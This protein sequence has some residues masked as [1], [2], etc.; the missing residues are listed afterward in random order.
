M[1]HQPQ[2]FQAPD[3]TE[4]VVLTASDYER[5]A[6]LAEDAEDI[7]AGRAGLASIVQDGAVPG[8]VVA[9]MIRDGLS[10][11]AAWRRHRGLTQTELARRAGLS[12][13]WVNRI[14]AGKGH[15]T[16]ATRSRL[17]AALD[18]PGWALEDAAD[19]DAPAKEQTVKNK[20]MFKIEIE[21]QL[22]HAR[23]TG[24]TSLTLSAGDVHRAVGGYPGPGHA[25]P[26]CC[27]ALRDMADALHAELVHSPPKGNGASLAFRFAIC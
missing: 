18:A 15:G 8:E 26:T 16:P 1:N 20:Q 21:R 10:P 23:Q 24:K 2:R 17:A 25:M 6:L 27:A 19:P 22:D 3:G 5:L 4:M 7:I 11:L 13:V 12:Q 14:E 9:L